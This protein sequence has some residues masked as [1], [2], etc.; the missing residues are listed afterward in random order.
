MNGTEIHQMSADEEMTTQHNDDAHMAD[1][2]T[3]EEPQP[4]LPLARPHLPAAPISSRKRYRVT[5]PVPVPAAAAVERSVIWQAAENDST[6]D[7]PYYR[8]VADSDVGATEILDQQVRNNYEKEEDEEEEEAEVE[9]DVGAEDYEEEEDEGEAVEADKEEEAVEAEVEEEAV[10]DKE[11]V[12]AEE[13]E[14]EE[15]EKEKEKGAKDRM[16][17]VSKSQLHSH[18]M[19]L[20]TH[21]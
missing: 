12:E 3:N 18:A 6:I 5:A 4:L 19:L 1:E 16:S 14:E 9:V 15:E 7:E 17:Q 10:A 20:L 13:E 8:K 2:P 21:L 11:A